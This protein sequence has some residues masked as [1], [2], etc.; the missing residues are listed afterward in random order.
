MLDGPQGQ[1]GY[2][3]PKMG[4][5]SF[6]VSRHNP[7]RNCPQKKNEVLKCVFGGYPFHLG[8]EGGQK[9]SA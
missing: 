2:A 4:S 6:W 8:F 1:I 7:K 5:G 9:E 3:P